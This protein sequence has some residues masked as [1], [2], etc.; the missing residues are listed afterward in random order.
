MIDNIVDAL[1]AAGWT[2]SDEGVIDRKGPSAT[3][4]TFRDAL[5]RALESTV[6]RR[7]LQRARAPKPLPPLCSYVHLLPSDPEDA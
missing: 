2:C 7:M 4:P 3:M 5:L 1:I 6:T